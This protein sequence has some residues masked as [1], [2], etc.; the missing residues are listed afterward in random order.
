MVAKAQTALCLE[1]NSDCE[2]YYAIYGEIIGG[3]FPCPP[4]PTGCNSFR[5]DIKLA[6]HTIDCSADHF[7]VGSK[8]PSGSWSSPIGVSCTFRYTRVEIQQLS[9]CSGCGVTVGINACGLSP[10]DTNCGYTATWSA[11]P[12]GVPGDVTITWP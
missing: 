7:V 8:D 9:P 10:T 11:T 1:N 6:P 3:P 12:G 2:V 5:A 4:T